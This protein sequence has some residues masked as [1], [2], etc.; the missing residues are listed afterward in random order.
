MTRIYLSPPHVGDEE[1]ALMLDAFESNWIAP[2]GPHVDGFER[3]MCE[4]LGCR[5]AVA[6][7]SGTAALHLALATAGVGPGDRVLTSTLTF[8][9]SANAITY[10]GAT[11]VFVDA[12]P[13]SWNLDPA[14]LERAID[15][16]APK[17]VLAVDIYGQCADY[18]RILPLCADRGIPVIEDAAEALGSTY[19]GRAAGTLG[20][21]GAL[22][23]NGNKIITTG[24]GGMLVS[25][26]EAA[27]A[28]ARHLSTQAREPVLHYEHND[29]GYNYRL[30][31]LL[32]AIGRGQLRTLDDKVA[33]YRAIFAYYSTRLGAIGGLEPMPQPEYGRPNSWLSCF[34]AP[35]AAVRDRIISSLAERQIEAR[36]V[37]KPMHLQPAYA[38]A[39]AVGGDVARD[40]F[41]RGFCLPSGS[42]LTEAELDA[43]ASVVE[44]SI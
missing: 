32:A 41:E 4:R 12:E 35:S 18:D 1:R 2:L 28:R 44:R 13:T 5:A 21:M 11:P 6:L 15:E 7:S 24:G 14:L 33:R 17:A 30:S 20:V 19:R 27:I 16:H 29:I 23:F 10:V 40:L 25:D 43:I 36:P 9:A 34:T 8:I 22:S 38:H 3:D 37:W 26:D 31:N 42:S 39:P